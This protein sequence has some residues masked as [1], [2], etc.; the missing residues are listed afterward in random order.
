LT[1]AAAA[2]AQVGRGSF[3]TG[4]DPTLPFIEIVWWVNQEALHHGGEIALL[5]DLYR[6]RGLRIENNRF[7]PL[8]SQL[9]CARGG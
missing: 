8:I 6:A 5:R 1:S 9:Y 2:L 7:V 3:P 4:L